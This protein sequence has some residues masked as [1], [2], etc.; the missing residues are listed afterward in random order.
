MR[1]P[2]R[3]ATMCPEGAHGA[4]GN[5]RHR[6]QRSGKHGFSHPRGLTLI[7]YSF[8]APAGA[9]TWH[10]YL[11]SWK[12]MSSCCDA[13]MLIHALRAQTPQGLGPQ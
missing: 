7:A 4:G 6:I 11:T 8:A 9:L 13:G 5:H 1:K 3:H 10:F 12:S 2:Y